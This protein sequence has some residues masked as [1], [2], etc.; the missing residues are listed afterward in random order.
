MNKAFNMSSSNKWNVEMIKNGFERFIAENGRLPTAIEIDRLDYLPSSRQI[1]RRFGGLEKLRTALGYGITNFAKGKTRS[2]KAKEINR[3][4]LEIEESI[5]KSLVEKFGEPSV[6]IERPFKGSKKRVDFYIFCPDGNFAV[7]VFFAQNRF[8]LISILNIKQKTYKD[9]K[10]ILYFVVANQ[11]IDEEI[12][13]S[14][15]KNKK[16][17]INS[18][19]LIVSYKE[20]MKLIIDKKPYKWEV[21]TK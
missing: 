2:L 9:F 7:D 15:L 4:S 10:E 8:Y 19:I 3:R 17:K 14:V 5:R 20:F 16:N 21:E 12:I 11:E 6:H 1:Q 13:Q 18:N